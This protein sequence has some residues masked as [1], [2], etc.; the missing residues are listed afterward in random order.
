[1]YESPKV[2]RR[3]HQDRG[4]SPKPTKAF[5]PYRTP[6]FPARLCATLNDQTESAGAHTAGRHKAKKCN[7][8]NVLRSEVNEVSL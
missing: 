1:M 3:R 2:M 5:R 8:M 4:A 7:V 6:K